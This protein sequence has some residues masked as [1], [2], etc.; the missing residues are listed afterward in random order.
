MEKQ[1]IIAISVTSGVLSLIFFLSFMFKSVRKRLEKHIQ[2][3]FDEN[4]IIG[5][6]A[7]ANFLGERSKGGKQLRENGAIVLTKD[8]LSFIRA[9]PLKEYIIPVK[10]IKHVSMPTSFNGRSVFSKLLCVH[11]SLKGKEDS[12]AWAIEN[13]LKWKESIEAL[14]HTK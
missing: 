6:S 13:P 1:V 10:S 5:A 11:Y 9:M 2:E 7:R 12:I 4:E 14:I 3:N 8:R